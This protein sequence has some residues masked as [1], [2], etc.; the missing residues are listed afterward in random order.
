VGSEVASPCSVVTAE[1]TSSGEAVSERVGAHDEVK[2][3]IKTR[4]IDKYFM[5][6]LP[7]QNNY[8]G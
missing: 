8:V 2:M 1:A 3:V 6:G 5:L 7:F 4:I